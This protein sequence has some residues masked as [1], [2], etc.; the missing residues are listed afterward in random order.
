MKGYKG[1]KSDMTCR[2]MQYEI[3]KTYHEDDVA[4]CQSGLHF[5]KN[6]LDVFQFYGRNNSNRFF[7]V[8]ATGNIVQGDDKCCASDLTIIRELTDIEVSRNCYGYGNGTGN[9]NFSDCCY[10]NGVGY[11]YSSVF[12]DDGYGDGYN[13]G[14]GNGNGNG[15]GTGYYDYDNDEGYNGS[16]KCNNIQEILI[17]KEA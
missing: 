5:C 17:F 11:G 9:Y 4:L 7:E 12:A 16:Y 3:G 10:G 8:E 2:G 15:N 13:W 1:M 6:L 14:N